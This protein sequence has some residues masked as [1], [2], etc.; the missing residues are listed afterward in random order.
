M[1]PC[2]L[3]V[4][5][6]LVRALDK[7]TCSKG[8]KPIR[9]DAFQAIFVPFRS[10]GSSINEQPQRF[11]NQRRGVFTLIFY[12]VSLGDQMYSKLIEPHFYKGRFSPHTFLSSPLDSRASQSLITQCCVLSQ[13]GTKALGNNGQEGLN[14]NSKGAS[15]AKVRVCS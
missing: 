2:C 4:Q 6:S 11:L 14:S 13:H 7:S 8:H 5:D 3:L 12:V 10:A 15:T 9:R 1:Y